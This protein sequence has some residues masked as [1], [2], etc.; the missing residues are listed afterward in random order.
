MGSQEINADVGAVAIILHALVHIDAIVSVLAQLVSLWTG[1][2]VSTLCIRAHMRTTALSLTTLVNV[3]AVDLIRVQSEALLARAVIIA[4]SIHTLLFAAS[5]RV[6]ALINI[7]TDIVLINFVSLVALAAL[8]V[9]IPDPHAQ[10]TLALNATVRIV[11]NVA[12]A[13]VAM[14]TAIGQR[15]WQARSVRLVFM[16][17]G[18][19]NAFVT[20]MGVQADAIRASLAA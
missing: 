5:F 9:I 16:V 7:D 18:W 2:L 17:V 12:A 6:L 15:L 4:L 13:S 14:G 20:S 8:L 11:A 1:A 10:R 3:I 19:A